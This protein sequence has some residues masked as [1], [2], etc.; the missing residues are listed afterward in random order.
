MLRPFPVESSVHLILRLFRALFRVLVRDV[1]PLLVQ[2]VQS[3]LRCSVYHQIKNL[4]L[5]V[6]AKVLATFVPIKIMAVLLMH[7]HNG[8]CVAVV[9]MLVV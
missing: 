5:V 7:N 3:S 4:P 1:V 9:R 2:I 6:L 8:V